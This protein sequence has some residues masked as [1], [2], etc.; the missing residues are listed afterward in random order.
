[1]TDFLAKLKDSAIGPYEPLAK[2]TGC[3]DGLAGRMAL[4]LSLRNIDPVQAELRL[5]EALQAWPIV[6][7]VMAELEA[8]FPEEAGQAARHSRRVLD[9]L[10]RRDRKGDYA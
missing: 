3:T 10:D 8:A 2:A 4:A 7:R 6:C 5:V 9:A 1:M